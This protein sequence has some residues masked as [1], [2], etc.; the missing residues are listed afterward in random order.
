MRMR[1]RRS[2]NAGLT[3]AGTMLLVGL[4]GPG[5]AAA[6]AQTYRQA[7]AFPA[8]GATISCGSTEIQTI[9]G[10]LVGQFHQTSDANG[11]FHYEGTNV[12]RDV[13][14]IDA[15][16]E[17]YRVI[18]TSSFSGTSIDASG[19]DNVRW[20][21][22]VELVVLDSGGA[23]IGKVDVVEHLVSSRDVVLSLGECIG[24]GGRDDDDPA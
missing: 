18:G 11:R 1:S 14:G 16:G 12:A 6:S 7:V 22:T 19:L 13:E 3:A 8:A 23:R 9:A 2:L 5:P 21:N 10:E 24:I 20:H 4:V 15:L 17:T